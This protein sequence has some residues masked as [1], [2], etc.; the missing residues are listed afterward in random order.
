[1]QKKKKLKRKKNPT[2]LFNPKPPLVEQRFR[3]CL[4]LGKI[5]ERERFFPCLV[6]E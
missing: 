6:W 4:E 3:V 1:M 5:K 2:S